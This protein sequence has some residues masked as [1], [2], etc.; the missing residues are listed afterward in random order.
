M[1]KVPILGLIAM[2]C[3]LNIP[4]NTNMAAN[5]ASWTQTGSEVLDPQEIWEFH[6]LD[7]NVSDKLIWT[8]DGNGNNLDFWLKGPGGSTG[9]YEVNDKKL[10]SGSFMVPTE[11]TWSFVWENTDDS[12]Y[13]SPVDLDYEITLEPKNLPPVAEIEAVPDNGTAPLKVQFNSTSV[14][15]DGTIE[16]WYWMIRPLGVKNILFQTDDEN[17]THTFTQAGKYNVT[18]NITDDDGEN[19]TAYVIIDVNARPTAV[20]SAS[21]PIVLTNEEV[22]FDGSSSSDADGTIASYKWYFG[23]GSEGDGAQTTHR[24]EMP[25][26]YTVRLNVTDDDGANGT[27]TLYVTASDT[28]SF[29]KV[30]VAV[31]MSGLYCSFGLGGGNLQDLIWPTSIH[32]DFGDGNS[33]DK[34]GDMVFNQIYH[35]YSKAGIYFVEATALFANGATIKV[36]ITISVTE[37]GREAVVIQLGPYKW[38]DGT[39][40]VGARVVLISGTRAT[41]TAIT[42]ENGIAAFT[43]PVDFGNYTYEVT[44]TEGGK[45]YTILEGTISIDVDT[46]S[47][48]TWWPEDQKDELSSQHTETEWEELHDTGEEEPPVVTETFKENVTEDVAVGDE[49]VTVTVSKVENDTV[50]ATIGNDEVEIKKD[51]SVRVD[52]DGDGVDDVE[53]T[54]MGEDENGQPILKFEDVNVDKKAEEGTSSLLIIGIILAILV[55]II[56]IFLVIRSKGGSEEDVSGEE[57]YEEEEEEELSRSISEEEISDEEE[58]MDE[59]FIELSGDE[60]EEE[61][62]DIDEVDVELSG[63]EEEGEGEGELEDIDEVD[64]EL[65]GDEEE[66]ELEDIDEVDVEVSGDEEEG[67]L[68]DIDEEAVEVSGDEEGGELKDIDEVDVELSG[69]EEEGELEELENI[70]DL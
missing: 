56:F 59:E 27:D 8:W 32:W 60:E 31:T 30:S 44:K 2:L 12:A 36:N 40:I 43:D 37:T 52:S 41:Y 19:G 70:D 9:H 34:T 65:S 11:G 67:E 33:G 62:E 3:I 68:E 54:Y 21:K 26:T 57:E 7:L 51:E 66:G 64:V 50:T 61:L 18:L 1:K 5:A 22:T 25:G 46:P 28:P 55:L 63:D 38:E 45:T 23:D 58:E 14:D 10:D 16:S 48:E 69:D 24:Y 17:F 29:D 42:D 47:N 15:P 6:L 13:G 49:T 53:I 4:L 39:P 20:A 35:T